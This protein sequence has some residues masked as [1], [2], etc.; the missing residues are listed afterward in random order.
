MGIKEQS[1]ILL[2]DSRTEEQNLH[3]YISTFV[4]RPI[5]SKKKQFKKGKLIEQGSPCALLEKYDRE[6]LEQ[7]FLQLSSE[8]EAL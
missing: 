5:N 6:N 3:D 4:E 8:G 7:V 1:E 2:G